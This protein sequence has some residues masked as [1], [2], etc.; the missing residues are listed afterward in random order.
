MEEKINLTLKDIGERI[1]YFR[2]EKNLSARELS[3]MIDK[4]G[5]YITRLEAGDINISVIALIEIL[6][7]LGVSAQRF[8]D[9]DYKNYYTDIELKELIESFT[10]EKREIVLKFLQLN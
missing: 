1:A 9:S 7:V 6:N 4:S 5:S 8:F 10:P 2:Y 3:F